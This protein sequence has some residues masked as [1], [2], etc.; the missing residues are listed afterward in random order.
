MAVFHTK[1]MRSSIQ[2]AYY[3]LRHQKHAF[4]GCISRSFVL[5]IASSTIMFVLKEEAGIRRRE[6]PS[7]QPV[8]SFV[9]TFVLSLFCPRPIVA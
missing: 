9:R 7:N 6:G 5:F 8:R 4:C 2:N 3:K 1:V